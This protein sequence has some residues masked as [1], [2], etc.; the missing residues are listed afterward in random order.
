MNELIGNCDNGTIG[1]DDPAILLMYQIQ[2]RRRHYKKFYRCETAECITY[3]NFDIPTIAAKFINIWQNTRMSTDKPRRRSFSPNDLELIENDFRIMLVSS[4][5]IGK[6]IVD[7]G[8]LL[9]SQSPSANHVRVVAANLSPSSRN[10]SSS[11]HPTAPVAQ[12]NTS[13][14][15]RTTTPTRRRPTTETSHITPRNVLPL[16]DNLRLNS[17]KCTEDGVIFGESDD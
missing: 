1:D 6:F 5:I 7:G 3:R 12:N 4:N 11:Y 8:R 9:T 10:G 14:T 15:A 13:P 2:R 17:L 16:P